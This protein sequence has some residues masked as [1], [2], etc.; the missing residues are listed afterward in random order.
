MPHVGETHFEENGGTLDFHNMAASLDEAI[1][2]AQ[3]LATGFA[4]SDDASDASASAWRRADKDDEVRDNASELVKEPAGVARVAFYMCHLLLNQGAAAA[5]D[6]LESVD[7]P[8]QE[9]K[10]FFQGVH[11]CGTLRNLFLCILPLV[12]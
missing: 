10:F 2:N 3:K 1:A 5:E 11:S 9:L 4:D 6:F 12:W 7:I 8:M